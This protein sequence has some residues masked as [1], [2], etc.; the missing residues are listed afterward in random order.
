MKSKPLIVVWAAVMWGAVVLGAVSRLSTKAFATPLAP[1]PN[2]LLML[3][4]VLFATSSLAHAFYTLG[5]H[6]ALC[7]FGVATAVGYVMEALAIV[8]CE[9]QCY[10]YT[11]AL[12]PTLGPVPLLIPIGW[13]NSAYVAHCIVNL[14]ADGRAASARGGPAWIV[15]LALTTA[16][17]QTAWDLA[18]DPTMV[19]VFKAWSWTPAGAFFGIPL[20]NYLGW[21]EVA[22][23]M[24]LIYRFSERALP[25]RPMGAAGVG[26][27]LVPVTSYAISGATEIFIAPEPTTLIAV[28]A[29][30]PVT[31]V[32]A[33]HALA[34]PR[35]QQVAV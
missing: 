33:W 19:N 31:L 16:L 1:Q 22:L 15:A 10:S 35:T 29:L 28:F 14:I 30:G 12:G 23:I 6:R 11:S 26:L 3:S 21:V 9:A 17:V 5:R 25:L 27:T 20:S 18:G 24:A 4:S 8:A 7:F 13:F 2:A 34:N 32:A